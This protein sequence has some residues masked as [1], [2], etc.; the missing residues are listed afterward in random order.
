MAFSDVLA[1][2][3]TEAVPRDHPTTSSPP[4]GDG[5]NTVP[6]TTSENAGSEESTGGES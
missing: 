5:E 6:T 4:S 2:V 3:G 1:G